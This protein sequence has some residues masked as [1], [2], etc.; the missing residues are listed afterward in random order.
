MVIG[1]QPLEAQPEE[2]AAPVELDT[3]GFM[4]RCH[5]NWTLAQTLIGQF[6]E[7]RGHMTDELRKAMQ[8]EDGRALSRAAHSIKGVVSVFGAEAIVSRARR[9]EELGNQGDVAEGKRIAEELLTD[10]EALL[11]ALDELKAP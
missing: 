6:R 1:A 9:V 11:L 2:P 7:T 4:R 5:N 3:A 10:C 8:A